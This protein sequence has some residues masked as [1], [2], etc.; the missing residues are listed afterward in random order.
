MRAGGCLCGGIRYVVRGPLRDVLVCH[1]VECRRWTG[2][3]WAATAARSTDLELPANETLAWVESPHSALGASRGFC[4]RCGTSLF[5][6]A[7]GSEQISLA[8]G[9]LDDP[10]ALR[11]AAHIWVEQ[12]VPWDPPPAGLPTHPRGYPPEAPPLA[13][14]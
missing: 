12:A 1:C 5:W 2:R 3:A 4:R 11:V 7:P 6:R 13:W 14:R 9:T 10:S 8:A